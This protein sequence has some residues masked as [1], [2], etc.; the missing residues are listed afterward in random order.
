MATDFIYPTLGYD[1]PFQMIR[2]VLFPI[3]FYDLDIYHYALLTP[4]LTS[5]NS[6]V[7]LNYGPKIWLLNNDAHINFDLLN[8]CTSHK[9]EKARGLYWEQEHL[10]HDIIDEKLSGIKD[11]ISRME[12]TNI[13][14]SK[15]IHS[16]KVEGEKYDLDE[17]N[18]EHWCSD[19][20][21][22]NR[23]SSQIDVF[24]D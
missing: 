12:D 11:W 24:S 13:F 10:S 16:Y 7:I 15:Y 18:C 23:V 4:Y 3:P 2:C 21:Y 6:R 20:I 5:D 22:G 17:N 1:E 19:I 9:W 14:G 8:M